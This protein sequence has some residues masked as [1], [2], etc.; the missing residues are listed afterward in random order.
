MYMY[1]VVSTFEYR[2]Y[3]EVQEPYR[4][5]KAHPVHVHVHSI[6]ETECI[7]HYLIGHCLQ[8][9]YMYVHVT[10][11]KETHISVQVSVK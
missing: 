11:L 2:M 6:P 1:N 8:H 4:S 3:V 5:S 10:L 9:T 7:I